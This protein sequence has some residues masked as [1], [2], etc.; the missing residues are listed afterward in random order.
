[1]TQVS[2]SFSSPCAPQAEVL[3][4]KG[5][6]RR[7]S[8]ALVPPLGFLGCVLQKSRTVRILKSGR[9]GGFAAAQEQAVWQAGVPGNWPLLG[10][11][12]LTELHE[13]CSSR[14]A[15]KC[16]LRGSPEGIRPQDLC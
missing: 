8:A 14:A 10:H 9:E 15:F 1:M 6:G 5:P 11:P 4:E 16:P 12:A 2:L 3:L 13:M 7:A